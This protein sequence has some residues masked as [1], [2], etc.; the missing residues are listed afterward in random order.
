M[1][2]LPGA[3]IEPVSP[4]LASGF[5]STAPPGKSLRHTL[6]KCPDSQYRLARCWVVVWNEKSTSGPL[7]WIL[8]RQAPW[9]NL[10]LTMEPN[11]YVMERAPRMCNSPYY[12]LSGEIHLCFP[13][14]TSQ[15][16]SSMVTSNSVHLVQTHCLLIT[17]PLGPHR[18]KLADNQQYWSIS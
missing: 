12:K 5:L 4:A 15:C 6:L 8:I 11:L 18:S 14:I 3:G 10:S 9:S 13:T 16:I 1:W 2:D 17:V 7:L